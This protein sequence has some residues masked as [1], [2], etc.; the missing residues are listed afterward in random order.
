[1][2]RIDLIFDGLPPIGAFDLSGVTE[3]ERRVKTIVLEVREN[4]PLVLAAAAQH[5]VVDI[6]THNISLE[7]IFLAYY[8]KENGGENV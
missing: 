4:L 7:D 8:D 3:L 6:E 2:N 1:M 5:N